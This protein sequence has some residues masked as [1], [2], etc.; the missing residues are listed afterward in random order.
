MALPTLGDRFDGRVALVTGSSRNL[1][2]AI[3][4]R[5]A[6]QGATLAIHY[7][8]DE[9]AARRVVDDISAAGG[10]AEAFQADATDGSQVRAMG[11]AVLERFSRID[12]LVDAVGPYADMPF[13]TLSEAGNPP[14]STG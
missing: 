11:Q 4:R 5:L 7:H 10:R 9:A 6:G 1:G 8:Q 12:I 2:A 3:A 14:W 13:G